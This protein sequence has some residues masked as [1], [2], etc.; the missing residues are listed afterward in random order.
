MLYLLSMKKLGILGAFLVLT[1]VSLPGNLLSAHATNNQILLRYAQENLGSL[2]TLSDFNISKN[3]NFSVAQDNTKGIVMTTGF[4]QASSV[5]L[6]EQMAVDQ[7]SPGFST[8]FVMNVYKLNAG[9]GDG[10]VFII[11][12]NSNSLGQPGGGLGYGGI[13]NSI[14][15]EF[16]FYD[17]GGEFIAS[18]DIFLNGVMPITA[19]TRF[20]N[21]FVTKWNNASVNTLVRSYHTWIEY[22]YTNSIFELRV[23]LSDN[24]DPTVSRPTRPS[25]ALIRKTSFNVPQISQFFFA[26]FSAGTGG[27]A[28]MNGLKSWYFSNAYI[29]GGIDVS[30]PFVIDNVAPTQ[31]A[32]T[33]EQGTPYTATLSG[34]TDNNEVAGYQYRTPSSNWL[35]YTSPIQMTEAGTYQSRT[36]DRAGNTSL[37]SLFSRIDLVY[38]INNQ[39]YASE[40]V[41]V[42]GTEYSVSKLFIVEPYRYNAWFSSRFLTGNEITSVSASTTAIALYGKPDQY[43][44]TVNFQL[45]NGITE[46]DLPT[47]FLYDET[48]DVPEL[49]R[50]GHT[51]FGWYLDQNFTQPFVA[52]VPLNRDVTLYAKWVVNSYS[53]VFNSNEGTSVA[54][55]NQNYNSLLTSP[56]NPTRTG[57]TFAGWHTD[58]ALTLSYSFPQTMPAEDIEVFAKWTINQYSITFNS[59]EGSSVATLTQ[60]FNTPLLV[61]SNPTRTGYSFDGWFTDEALNTAYVFPETMPAQTID[62]YAK[63][64]INQYS[65]SFNSNEGTSVATMTEDFNASLS[66]PA[67]PTRTGYTFAGWFANES[68]TSAYSFPQTMPAEDIEVFAKWT[69][70]QYSISF[71]TNEGSTISTLTQDYNSSIIPPLNPTRTGYTFDGWFIDE[72]LTQPFTFPSSTPAEDIQLFAKWAINSYTLTLISP[73]ETNPIATMSVPFM[74]TI[75]SLQ[76]L[77][78]E[79]YRFIGW[80][81]GNNEVTVGFSIPARDVTLTAR[82]EG[83]SSTVILITSTSTTILTLTSGQA[84]GTLPIPH[85]KTGYTFLGW[86]L[87]ANSKDDLISSS[88]VVENGL[89]IRLYPIW[90]KAPTSLLTIQGWVNKDSSSGLSLVDLIT[91]STLMSLGVFML[92]SYVRKSNGTL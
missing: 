46:D 26:G 24:S 19:G 2:Q 91:F 4:G 53:I 39:N 27:A 85:T 75:S 43:L 34:G 60:D 52:N 31:P 87:V 48:F 47:S 15:V 35:A 14:G 77:S 73:F 76:P 80:F 36:V 51:F 62:L 8:Y 88:T 6:K 68:L 56:S 40:S 17:N 63:W 11:S 10:Y 58:E 41:H 79:G 66:I 57:Y 29:P 49:T 67:N 18:S 70:N 20:D 90:E 13:N 9:S 89:T 42:L 65:I 33:L 25:T 55:I 81:D 3:S 61:P 59:N 44:F 82:F 72:S 64:T 45:D 12:A 28:Q 30:Q 84:I 21:G 38:Y 54:T 23:G 50:I 7:S 86:S 83:L 5:F 74:S 71:N 22:D 37:I 16:D 1:G 92:W 78:R 69:I 32:V